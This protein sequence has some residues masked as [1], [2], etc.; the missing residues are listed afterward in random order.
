MA[1]GVNSKQASG[2]SG[3]PQTTIENSEARLQAQTNEERISSNVVSEQKHSDYLKNE[4]SKSSPIKIPASANIKEEKKNRYDQVKYTWQK[5]DYTYTSR[6]HTRTPGAPPEQ[7][8]SWVVQRDKPGVGFGKSARPAKHDILVGHNKWI[9][10]NKW[11][12]AIRARKNGTATNKQKEL[13][14]NGHWKA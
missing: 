2:T 13:I 14:D 3:A 4:L 11:K 5:G 10:L 8:D 12:E 7:G 6:W 9:S 1:D